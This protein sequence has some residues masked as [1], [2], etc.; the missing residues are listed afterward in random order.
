M[1]LYQSDDADVFMREW[2]GRWAGVICEAFA[3]YGCDD[4]CA[5]EYILQLHRGDVVRRSRML[6]KLDETHTRYWIY[7]CARRWRR[8]W[9]MKHI[10]NGR[11]FSDA[12]RYEENGAHTM[13]DHGDVGDSGGI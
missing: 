13:D 9:S 10:R 3:A 2:V 12:R 8:N 6:A 11:F 5:G 7:G 4:D 1:L